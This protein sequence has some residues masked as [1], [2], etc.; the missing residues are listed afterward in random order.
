MGASMSGSLFPGTD[1]LLMYHSPQ[2]VA[3]LPAESVVPFL[4]RQ[5]DEQ[6][7]LPSADFETTLGLGQLARLMKVEGVE[8]Q[9]EGWLQGKDEAKGSDTAAVFLAG[10]WPDNPHPSQTL[11][12]RLL[13]FMLR[14][15]DSLQ[16]VE[17]L[18]LALSAALAT[19]DQALRSR[20]RDGL[21]QLLPLYPLLQTTSQTLLHYGLPIPDDQLP[22]TRPDLSEF[23]AYACETGDDTYISVEHVASNCEAVRVLDIVEDAGTLRVTYKINVLTFNDRF[24]QDLI[25]QAVLR[26]LCEDRFRAGNDKIEYSNPSRRKATTVSYSARQQ[27]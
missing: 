2:Q 7:A 13:A 20:I 3:S 10:F 12:E 6:A 15:S 17:T 9:L 22:K 1:E 11:V 23:R 26:D 18:L 24:A 27:S 19:Q 14:H 16:V 21:R 8:P 5:L 4:L 25:A